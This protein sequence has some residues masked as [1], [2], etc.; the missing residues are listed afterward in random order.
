MVSLRWLAGLLTVTLVGAASYN[1]STFA[2]PGASTTN[3]TGINNS[4]TLVGAYTTGSTSHGFFANAASGSFQTVDYPGATNTR[5]F[6]INNNGVATGEFNFGIAGQAPGWFTVD[7]AGNF[8]TIAVPSQYSLLA[9]YGISDNGAMSAAVGVT[10]QS[11][12]SFAILNPDGTVTL[13][14]GFNNG[15]PGQSA[16]GSINTAPQM[17]ESMLGFGGTALADASGNLT[18]IPIPHAFGLNNSG[19]VVGYAGSGPNGG[20][21]PWFG[22]SRDS[23][24]TISDVFC[25]GNPF[26][27]PPATQAINDNGVVAGGTV[28]L[29]P[30]PGQPQISLSTNTL[31]FPPAPIGQ[32]SAVQNVTLTNT[33]NTR[34]DIAA[35]S[36]STGEIMISGCLDPVTKMASLDA[37][38]SCTLGL[39]AT[40][41][42]QGQKTGSVNIRDSVPGSPHAIAVSVTGTAKPPS[43]QI[44]SVLPGP[45]KQVNFTMQD[46]NSG[47]KSIVLLDSFNAQVNIPN[48][49]QGST[50][51]ITAAATQTDASQSSK[52]DLQ[53]TNVAGAATTCGSVFGGP[54]SWTGLGGSFSGKIALARD[55]SDLMH[56]FVRGG[57][58]ALW[59]MAQTSS[60]GWSGWESL[61]GFL[62]SDPIVAVPN[63]GVFE[64]IEVFA[65]GGDAALWHIRQFG[66]GSWSAWA[67][68]GG[69]LIGNP[70][71]IGD[72]AGHLEVFAAGTDHALWHIAQTSPGGAWGD[73]GSFGGVLVSDPAVFVNGAGGIEVFVLG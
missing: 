10:G 70:G 20:D 17:L 46:T 55:F 59:H 27:N 24:G 44:S 14:P 65:V 29:T 63:A 50:V 61:G 15:S 26:F 6:T 12:G 39:S 57:D 23:T 16:P 18:T 40:P 66:P 54:S 5:L 41:T 60:G 71:V 72:E 34:L 35:I 8:T 28:I 67:S 13:L 1:C 9:V 11:G 69:A 49:V 2:I 73:W 68:L 33:G 7:A 53:A 64:G 42:V 4:G 30:L 3:I 43:C 37:G 36:D 62:S 48:F 52:V 47:L 21:A 25:P 22:F 51:A 56:V 38:A 32:T 19:T 31:T 58:N 45:P